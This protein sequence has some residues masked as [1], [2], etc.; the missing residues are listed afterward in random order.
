MKK[1]LAYT[2]TH[3]GYV[4]VDENATKEEIESAIIVDTL[5]GDPTDIEYGEVNE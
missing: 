5:L 3:I 1:I 2:V 4:E